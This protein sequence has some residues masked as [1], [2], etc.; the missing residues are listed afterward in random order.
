MFATTLL[1]GI[2]GMAVSTLASSR[3]PTV[4]ENM[5]SKEI[6]PAPMFSFYL[7][8]VE[9]AG[10]RRTFCKDGC[11]AIVNSCTALIVGPMR[12]KNKLNKELG[13]S[14]VLDIP[15]LHIFSCFRV[16]SLPDVDFILNGNRLTQTSA[17]YT[18]HVKTKFLCLFQCS[19]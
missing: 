5:V 2:Q 13:G 8:R 17:E 7:S 1:D 9:L 10:G 18:I 6:L 11:D 12:E 16:L 14:R 19:T 3:Q 4:F 15:G